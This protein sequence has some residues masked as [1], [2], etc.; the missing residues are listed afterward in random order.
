MLGV[1]CVKVY[2]CERVD[3]GEGWPACFVVTCT[4][5]FHNFSVPSQRLSV[6]RHFIVFFHSLFIE[7]NGAWRN[8]Q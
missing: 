6:D 2:E 1:I 3:R 8:C 7:N 5:S 4:L